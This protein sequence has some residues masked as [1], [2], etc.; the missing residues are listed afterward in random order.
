MKNH[1][2]VD[3]IPLSRDQVERA[4]QQLNWTPQPGDHVR[5]RNG[6][7]MEFVVVSDEL[8]AMLCH[9]YGVKSDEA[10]FTSLISLLRGTALAHVAVDDLELV[11]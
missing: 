2:I 9:R 1:V 4:L 10:G 5:V 7:P 11:Q 6:G 8:H 3:G